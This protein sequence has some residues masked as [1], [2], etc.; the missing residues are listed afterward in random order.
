MTPP[1]P[2]P[3]T[4]KGPNYR[5]MR[6]G[7]GLTPIG[8][9]LIRD[10]TTGPV[11]N[12]SGTHLHVPFQTYLNWPIL[13]Q[14]VLKMGKASMAHLDAAR[15]REA[16]K[17]ATDDMVLGSALHTAFLEPELAATHIAVWDGGARRGKEWEAYKS[18]NVGRIILTENANEKL[19]G[20]MRSLRRHP[21]VR[22]WVSKIEDTEVSVIGEFCGTPMK[23]RCDA[24]TPEPMFDLKKVR[25]ADAAMFTRT[26]LT[27]GYHIQAAIYCRLFNRKR[28]VMLAVE[29]DP[30]HDVVAYELSPAALRHGEQEAMGLIQRYQECE[31]R[32][33]WPG[34]SDE[35]VQ[36]D[37][38]EWATT[39]ADITIGD[40]DAF[41]E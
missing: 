39:G 11:I 6:A 27:F 38:P 22:Q 26:I 13:S 16:V 19:A 23:G 9:P 36:L 1:L 34:R 32:G 25:S 35:I 14:S 15:R 21:V 28:F 31:R 10:T 7:L 17:K 3:F 20:M 30:P 40:E 33:V 37:L 8:V 24:L 12:E 29:G 4:P 18:D 41:E 5:A 2:K